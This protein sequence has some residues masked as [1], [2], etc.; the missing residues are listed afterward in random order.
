[1][2]PCGI[3]VP[4]NRPQGSNFLRLFCAY[5]MDIINKNGYKGKRGDSDDP[6]YIFYLSYIQKTE[7]KS[8]TSSA[9]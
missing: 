8:S 9:K 5:L 2:T 4:K 3:F 1:M 6:K 7:R